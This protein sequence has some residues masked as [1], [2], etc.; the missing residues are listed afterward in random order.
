M[1]VFFKIGKAKYK[2]FDF[3]NN[4]INKIPVYP[5]KVI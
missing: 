1:C 4:I 3:I 2:I 5:K